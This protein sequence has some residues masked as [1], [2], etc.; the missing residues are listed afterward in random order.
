MTPLGD[1]WLTDLPPYVGSMIRQIGLDREPLD[2]S[3]EENEQAFMKDMGSWA[4][5]MG[6]DSEGSQV[7]QISSDISFYLL[8]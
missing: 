8:C 2:L 4:E 5:K 3:Q 6:K 1:N 7:R